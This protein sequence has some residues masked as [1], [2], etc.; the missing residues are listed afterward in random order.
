MKDPSWESLIFIAHQKMNNL[1]FIV[2]ANGLQ[3]FGT[4]KE[5]ADL[6]PLAEKFAT[7]GFE[8]VEVDGH[9]CQA[10]AAACELP[11]SQ[12]RAI[13]AKTTKGCGVSF[14]SH[15]MEWHYLPLK[16]DQYAPGRPGNRIVSLESLDFGRAQSSR[17]LANFLTPCGTSSPQTLLAAAADPRLVFLTGDLGFMALE[18]LRDA[19]GS[20][21][22]NAGVAEQNMV[23]RRRRPG[24][25]GISNPGAIASPHSCMPAHLEQIR[26]DVCLCTPSASCWSETA[27]AMDTGVMGATH[28]STNDYGTIGCQPRN[29]IYI[30]AFDEDAGHIIAITRVK[31]GTCIFAIWDYQNCLKEL[32]V[33]AYAPWRKLLS[34]S[35]GVTLVVCG[36]L[37]GGI[38][39]AA[40]KLEAS[41]R[42][43][44]WVVTEMPLVA[45][46]L[47]FL[48]DLDRS[49]LLIA[50]EEHVAA[51]G[52]GQ[53][54]AALLLSNGDRRSD[55][56]ICIR[57]TTRRAVRLAK[58]SPSRLRH[59]PGIRFRACAAL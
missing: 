15:K 10:I 29:Q 19:M 56:Y 17:G 9:D 3:G 41:D 5:V 48:D 28:H 36:P 58:I 51:G 42:P 49:R 23:S 12:P 2:D 33:A 14:M 40:M 4:T 27:A 55:L 44:L 32:D 54:L 13:I 43:T 7:F 53:G 52:M 46:P 30:P 11:Q 26:N 24:A 39:A 47:E 25:R 8:T 34:G 38:A 59:R 20:R 6:E 22:I 1:T 50:V 18:P 35:S 31:P 16:K 21:F 57:R 37:V 45:P